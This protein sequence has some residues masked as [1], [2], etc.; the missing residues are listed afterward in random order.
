MEV[1]EASDRVL[2]V[3]ADI[4][5]DPER[6]CQHSEAS[7]VAPPGY[8]ARCGALDDRACKWCL[9]GAVTKASYLAVPPR[10]KESDQERSLAR[11][12]VMTNLAWVV[13]QKFGSSFLDPMSV[14]TTFN[15]RHN[16]THSDVLAVLR[17]TK[18]HH[19][20]QGEQR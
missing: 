16:T 6:W 9:S 7:M 19:K 15:D 12:K 3:T 5:S 1:K 8:P 20:E 4:L 13:T 10:D 14:L 11:G 17:A 2:E 18:E